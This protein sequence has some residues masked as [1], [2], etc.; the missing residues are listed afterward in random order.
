[1]LINC[2]AV[3]ESLYFGSAH[4]LW[5][6]SVMEQDEAFDPMH[7]GFFGARRVL[8]ETDGISYLVEQFLLCRLRTHEGLRALA[9]TIRA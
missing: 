4:L 6:A 5:M 7:I 2:E 8:L 3:E 9:E 1:M